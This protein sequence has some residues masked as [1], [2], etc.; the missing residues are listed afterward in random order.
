VVVVVLEVLALLVLG[1]LTS[2]GSVSN[3]PSLLWLTKTEPST[4][5]FLPT[6]K[7]VQAKDEYGNK[8][9]H[10]AS[11]SGQ[12]PQRHITIMVGWGGVGVCVGNG[13]SKE[14]NGTNSRI[15]TDDTDRKPTSQR[16]PNSSLRRRD[17]VCLLVA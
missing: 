11:S 10:K 8:H 9:K 16:T 13:R 3:S 6:I 14:E 7:T 2:R 17:D 1:T 15:D 12:H 5:A 4:V